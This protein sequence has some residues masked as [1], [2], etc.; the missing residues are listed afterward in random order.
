MI[1]QEVRTFVHRAHERALDLLKTHRK[2]LDTLAEV[3]LQKETLEGKELEDL[4]AQ[5]LPPRG[6]EAPAAG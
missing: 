4:L 6:S 2:A 5:L 3:L 1:D